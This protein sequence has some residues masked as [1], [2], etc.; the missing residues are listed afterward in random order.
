MSS[1]RVWLNGTRDVDVCRQMFPRRWSWDDKLSPLSSV[2]FKNV[3]S[4]VFAL[5][6]ALMVYRWTTLPIISLHE[7]NLTF[8]FARDVLIRCQ[9]LHLL[10]AARNAGN[11]K[12]KTRMLS[13]RW[14]NSVPSTCTTLSEH[15]NRYLGSKYLSHVMSTVLSRSQR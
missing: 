13:G 7:Q 15:R 12:H 4:F 3:W 8:F 5:S 14:E 9:Q 1:T 11:Y 6:C 2:E 10:S